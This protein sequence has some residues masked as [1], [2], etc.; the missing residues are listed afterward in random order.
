M[1]GKPKM[2]QPVEGNRKRENILF[3]PYNQRREHLVDRTTSET[4]FFS[5]AGQIVSA[6]KNGDRT[7]VEQKSYVFA[8][9]PKWN[10]GSSS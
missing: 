10:R 7:R 8:S 6:N 3:W 9:Q 5:F 4:I 2:Y 1:K